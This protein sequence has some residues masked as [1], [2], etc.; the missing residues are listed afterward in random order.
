MPIYLRPPVHNPGGPD[1]QGW[2]RF[3]L[4][5][6][7]GDE[8]A[9]R[10]LHYGALLEVH[11]G[12]HR[13]TYGGYG[14]CIAQGDCETCPILQVGPRTLTAPGDRVLVR[15]DCDGNPHLMAHPEGGWSSR[16]IP[17]MWQDLARLNGWII[18]R[19]HRD[20]HGDGFWLSRLEVRR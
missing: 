4:G 11:A 12:T 14:P 10:P 8:C 5:S 7:A 1:G 13:A 6:L 3:S 15:V 17:C 9:L 16:S 18:G 19:W 20:E 2:N